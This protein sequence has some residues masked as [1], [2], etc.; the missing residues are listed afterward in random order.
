M[1]VRERP[2]FTHSMHGTFSN[3]MWA[4]TPNWTWRGVPRMTA[5]RHIECSVPV[6]RRFGLVVGLVVRRDRYSWTTNHDRG[7]WTN[8][9][10]SS[11]CR[12]SST[13]P[14][15]P[16]CRHAKR[17]EKGFI[18][19]Y[20]RWPVLPATCADAGCGKS[21]PRRPAAGRKLRVC[22]APCAAV[23]AV[24]RRTTVQTLDCSL[25]S[26]STL[27]ADRYNGWLDLRPTF[28]WYKS[29]SQANQLR[30]GERSETQPLSNAARQE[31]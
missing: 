24:H 17:D 21:K 23:R 8:A 31:V 9:F 2:A 11:A 30:R 12:L 20:R 29:R 27:Q 18:L 25:A 6:D 15:N 19:L 16:P 1:K 26:G 3:T 22:P 28:A 4:G 13:G 7:K 5:K 14:G 10:S